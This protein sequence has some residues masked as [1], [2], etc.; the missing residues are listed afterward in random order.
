MNPTPLYF[1]WDYNDADRAFW[2]EHLED[3]LPRRMFDAH[4]HIIDGRFRLEPMTDTMRRQYWVNEVLEPIDAATAE[5]CARLRRSC[6]GRPGTPAVWW[7]HE[8]AG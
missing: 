8:V 2:A 6:V 5:R 7:R 1:V 3:W 4:T